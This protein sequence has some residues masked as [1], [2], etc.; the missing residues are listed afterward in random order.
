VRIISVSNVLLNLL[1]RHQRRM[2][3]MKSIAKQMERLMIKYLSFSL[4]NIGV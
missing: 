2:K 1:I 4:E 3:E